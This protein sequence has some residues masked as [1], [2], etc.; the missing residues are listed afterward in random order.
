[1]TYPLNEKPLLPSHHIE[2]TFGSAI[3]GDVQGRALLALERYL[4]EE[5][6]VRAEVYKGTMLD[7]SKRRRD[8]TPEER[9]R[10]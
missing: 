10:L 3:A 1:M 9:K 2:V 4:R 7:D 8:M 5:L 6:F